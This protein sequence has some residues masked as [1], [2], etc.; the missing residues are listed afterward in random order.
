MSGPAPRATRVDFA[1]RLKALLETIFSF[2]AWF[3]PG[4][5]LDTAFLGSEAAVLIRAQTLCCL[6]R[7]HANAALPHCPNAQVVPER[8]RL[9]CSGDVETGLVGC[10]PG[11][12]SLWTHFF[13]PKQPTAVVLSALYQIYFPC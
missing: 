4:A 3:S 6:R 12:S 10:C 8:D 7:I 13:V 11:H 5:G 2:W 1:L 9:L